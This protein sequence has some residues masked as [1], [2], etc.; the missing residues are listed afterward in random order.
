MNQAGSENS[1]G[2]RK[3]SRTSDSKF[4]IRIM[5]MKLPSFFALILLAARLLLNAQSAA[6]A[7]LM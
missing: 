4:R 6:P 5:N 1:P 7:L 2:S 3:S